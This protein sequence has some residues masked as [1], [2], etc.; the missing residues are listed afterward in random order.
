MHYRLVASC[1]VRGCSKMHMCIRIRG[2]P[3]CAL[4]KHG[5]TQDVVRIT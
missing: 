2:G 4:Q 5:V 3:V 1:L